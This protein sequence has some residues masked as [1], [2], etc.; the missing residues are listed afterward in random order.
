MNASAPVLFDRDRLRH[1]RDRAAAHFLHHDFLVREAAARLHESLE[2]I[3][4]RFPCVIELGA[5]TGELAEL[6]AKREGTTTYIQCD[7][8]PAMLKRAHGLRVNADEEK[9]P[10]ASE[11]ADAVVSVLSLHWV[12][13]LPGT[14]KQIFHMLKPDGLFIAT[15][16][17]AETL[18]ELRHILADSESALR[19]GISPRVAPFADVRDAGAL[20][21]RA[22]FAL[23]VA[24]SEIITGSYADLPALTD[25][26]RGMGEVNML[27][28]QAKNFAPKRLFREA[29]KR[30][31][32]QFG[33]P[34][35]RIPASF[36]FLTLTGWKPAANQQQPLKR[37][38]GK[39]SLKDALN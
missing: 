10:F 18:R 32:Q 16:F 12:N 13:D 17:G 25:D 5:H 37:G 22:G 6:L 30:Y 39:V 15:F 3:R 33:D 7:L 9:L 2:H 1:Q 34:E 11:S 36:E 27:A 35:G 20:L 4:H 26:L 38:S 29:D 8:S 24:D 21:Q 19:G 14:L 28:S 31:R 23:P